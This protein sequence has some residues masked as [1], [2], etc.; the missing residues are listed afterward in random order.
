MCNYFKLV[1]KDELCKGQDFKMVPREVKMKAIRQ[2]LTQKEKEYCQYK[3]GF[4]ERLKQIEDV[5]IR[6]C[7]KLGM[8][9]NEVA[10]TSKTTSGQ[11]N[12]VQ[13]KVLNH[14]IAELA[15]EPKKN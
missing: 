15:K 11:M 6:V 10:A 12:L 3:Q 5:K 14:Y 9:L 4:I 2:Y 7:S 8:Y 1:K 13:T